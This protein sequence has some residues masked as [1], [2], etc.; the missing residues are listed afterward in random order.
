[1]NSRNKEGNGE[2]LRLHLVLKPDGGRRRGMTATVS[3]TALDAQQQARFDAEVQTLLA[4][5]IRQALKNGR[6]DHV[7][8]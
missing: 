5:L 8:F 7:Q 2:D 3:M 6:T 4:D 1:M